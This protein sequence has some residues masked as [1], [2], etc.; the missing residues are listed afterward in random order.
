M[1]R[2]VLLNILLLIALNLFAQS[3]SDRFTGYDEMVNQK[4]WF[5]NVHLMRQIDGDFIYS[6]KN[7]KPTP[8][9]KYELYT[10]L[11]SRDISV[12]GV[13]NYREKN[14]LEVYLTGG[15]YYLLI[16]KNTDFLAI[17]AL[18]LIGVI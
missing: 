7:D 14:Y 15:K 12:L 18:L 17:L 2:L 5:Y 16:N 11:S 4:V 1:K 6:F 13:Y 3:S 10:E 9:S 8:Q